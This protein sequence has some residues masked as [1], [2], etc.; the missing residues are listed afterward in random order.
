M[1]VKEAVERW[2]RSS[3]ES[4][5]EVEKIRRKNK[6]IIREFKIKRIKI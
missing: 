4:Y 2:Y 3:K 6:K 1:W 5:G